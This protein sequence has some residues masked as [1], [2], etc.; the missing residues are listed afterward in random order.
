MS[1]ELIAR[2]EKAETGSRNSRTCPGCGKEFYRGHDEPAWQ[3]SR[4][5][6]CTRLCGVRRAHRLRQVSIRDAFF[7]RVE[8]VQTDECINWTH[9]INA[10]GYG[11][12]G[13]GGKHYRAHR[14]SYEIH[15]GTISGEL[16]VMHSCDNR[17]C[18]NPRHLSLG[19]NADNTA[20]RNTKLRQAR[21][22]RCGRT[23]LSE[24]AVLM[25]RCGALSYREISLRWGISP[26]TI[27]GI[28]SGRIWRHLP[29]DR[30]ECVALLRAL[31]AKESEHG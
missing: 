22:V 29:L 2:L 15:H 30:N 1:A 3:W 6:H 16:C 26:S 5:H 28:R 4:H 10:Q 8:I 23:K 12:F 21:G 19:S 9:T 18:V 17:A 25:I 20:D 11:C 24:E 7:Q 31:Q 13:A 27:H 14:V